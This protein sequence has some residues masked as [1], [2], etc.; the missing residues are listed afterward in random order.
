MNIDAWS[1]FADEHVLIT[2]AE[3]AVTVG[4]MREYIATVQRQ[5]Q[6]ADVQSCALFS[7]DVLLFVVVFLACVDAGIDVVLPANNLPE[8]AGQ[9]KVDCLIGDW[10]VNA[11]PISLS[12]DIKNNKPFTAPVKTS[13]V[14]LFTSGSTGEPKS[15][16]RNINQLLAE[17]E[18]LNKT[19][20]HD[21]NELL[22]VSTVSHQ[23]I[24]GLLFTV[25]WPLLKGHAVWHKL[26]PFEEMID[27]INQLNRAWVLVSS[28]AFLKR[29]QE[30]HRS[31]Q[32]LVKVFSSGGVLTD[33][34][35]QYAESQLA[36][37]IIQVYGSSET[38]GI[39]YRTLGQN[40]QYFEAVDAEVREGQLWVKSPFC[41]CKD[42]LC[43]QDL[44]ETTKAGFKL[45]GRSD[46]IVKIEEKR[47]S[48]NMIEQQALQ[49]KWIVD[50]AALIMEENR[51]FIAAVF[52]INQLGV[53][54]IEQFGAAELKKN[55]KDS[56][57][58]SI[59][60]IALP[61]KIR[62]TTK[63]LVNAQGKKVNAEL[64]KLFA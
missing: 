33:E 45:L 63:P 60:K 3:H 30:D 40:W 42:W 26:L 52:E 4:Q 50:A 49:L 27:D 14:T 8:F 53:D 56:L 28:P 55:I 1:K 7:K 61:R 64:L 59:D 35:H 57:S 38:G 58:L 13:A 25:L 41:H 21:L 22:F 16:K 20:A 5:L 43:T 23:H 44:I 10:T 19:F 34:Q 15:I 48:L 62:F 11:L 51:Q 54:F 2:S 6:Q 47:I 18:V 31:N 32:S 29:I 24:Y 39:A 12:T 17:I 37:T 46:R 9:L 36:T